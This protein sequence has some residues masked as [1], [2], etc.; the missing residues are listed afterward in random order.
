[1]PLYEYR[2]NT[3]GQAFE[4]MVRFSEMDRT[5]TCPNCQSF[6]TQ[7]KLSTIVSFGASSSGTSGSS[8]GNCGSGGGFS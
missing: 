6:D 5:P 8:G 1:M 4:K 3:C 2:C 7:K